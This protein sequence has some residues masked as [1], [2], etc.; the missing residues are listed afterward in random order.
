MKAELL[1]AN[2]GSQAKPQ[3]NKTSLTAVTSAEK[4]TQQKDASSQRSNSGAAQAH[5]R[6]LCILMH[7]PLTAARIRSMVKFTGGSVFLVWAASVPD[8]VQTSR[9]QL[10]HR[11]LTIWA[12]VH[13]FLLENWPD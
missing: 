6:N 4:L 9:T 8:S 12:C 10:A 11:F 1:T 5:A 13:L 3:R 2:L 7:R